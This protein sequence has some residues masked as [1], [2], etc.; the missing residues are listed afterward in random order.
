MIKSFA[1]YVNEHTLIELI[2]K[3]RVKS[4]ASRTLSEE[5]V[6]ELH[7]EVQS[8]T[9]PRNTWRRLRKKTRNG[10]TS[11]AVLNKL[12]LR[13]TI[14]YD[15]KQVR[16]QGAEAPEYLKRLLD[17]ID[18]IKATVN[19]NEPLDF[20]G[21]IKVI[22]QFKKNDGDTA[23]YRPLS[24]YDNLKTKTLI[25]LA[26]GYLTKYLDGCLH[27]E[28]L[29]YRPK[30]VYHDSYRTTSG[31]DA[32]YG[33]QDFI[34]QHYEQ[35]IYVAECDIQKFYEQYGEDIHF[36]I[37]NCT[38]GSRETVDTAKAFIENAGYTFPVYY[39]TLSDAAMTYGV[40]A[41]PVTYF[42]DSSGQLIAY[43]QGALDA[44]TLQSGI[45]MILPE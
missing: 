26:S 16:G 40:N 25:S 9:P 19:S 24:V 13:N 8:M 5:R 11:T 32:I 10:I 17:F 42:I 28:I 2:I 36:L 12:S 7:L 22:A 18:D 15:L 14:R 3:E 33:I 37:V 29:A 39:D 31:E 38:D 21:Q 1:E 43:G 27:E 23:V 20:S 4:A 34:D 35:P 6:S 44:A 45:D 30:R 41:V